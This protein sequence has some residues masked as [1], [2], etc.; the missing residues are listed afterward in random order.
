MPK[1]NPSAS[2]GGSGASAGRIPQPPRS[3]VKI[4][5]NVKLVPGKATP[6][7]PRSKYINE[8]QAAGANQA[9]TQNIRTSSS[10]STVDAKA[11]TRGL[12]AANKPT[13]ASKSNKTAGSMKRNSK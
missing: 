13:T 6:V 1:Q 11:N 9:K 8:G 3:S 12:K 10:R 7:S 4:S 5:S 2:N